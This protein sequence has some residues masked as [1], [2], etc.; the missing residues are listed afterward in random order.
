MNNQ[1]RI[2]G[3]GLART[4]TKS[5]AV[6]LTRLGY[7]TVHW[8]LSMAAIDAHAA[9]TD[10]T[11]ACR[12]KELDRLYPG[13]RFILTIR[14]LESWIPSVVSHFTRYTLRYRP[15]RTPQGRFA[16]DAD[17]ILYDRATFSEP[18]SVEKFRRAYL[19]HMEDV[20]SYFQGRESDLMQFGLISGQGW[21]PLC[22]FLGKPVPESPFPHTNKGRVPA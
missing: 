13:S 3:I 18:I 6:A 22:D 10:S 4:G 21:A 7:R 2:F 16:E 9:A 1:G 5:L 19:R 8:P 12:F 17:R 20:S 11:V 14:D 15:P